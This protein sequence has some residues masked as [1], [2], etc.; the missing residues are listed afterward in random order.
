MT[1]FFGSLSNYPGNTGT[2]YYSKFFEEYKYQAE[3]NALGV[4]DLSSG[5]S[6]LISK[7]YKGFSLSMPFKQEIID[8]LEVSDSLC[9][10]Y[11]SCNTVLI[12]NSTLHGFNTDIYGVY[13]VVKEIPVDNKVVVLGN[14]C[15]GKMFASYLEHM[16]LNFKV[17]A[18]SLANWDE[19]HIA[20]TVIINC[21]PFGT[22]NTESPLESL[23]GV[24][25]VF[26]LTFNG[27]ELAKQSSKVEYYSGVFFYKEVFLQQ[28]QLYT[29]IVA[30]PEM[31]DYFTTI[32]SKQN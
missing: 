22:A 12:K 30:D 11:K 20:S 6:D 2:Y 7:G 25:K 1:Q 5:I 29:G 13:R 24:N 19:R 27:K 23:I 14:G 16:G 21:T 28:F 18:P 4:K 15:I 8:Y 31:F 17:F 9:Q 10:K 26:D 32:R 3:Y